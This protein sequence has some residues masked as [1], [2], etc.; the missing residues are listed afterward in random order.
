MAVAANQL[1]DVAQLQ[2]TRPGA[3]GQVHHDHDQRILTLAKTHQDRTSTG[4]AGQR[5][6]FEALWLEAAEH[7]IAVLGKTPEVAV[8]LLVPIREGTQL[9]QML[10]L[11]DVA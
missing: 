7:A 5:V 6:I 4:R 2:G 8:E 9:G 3:K 11:V 1:T 10:H